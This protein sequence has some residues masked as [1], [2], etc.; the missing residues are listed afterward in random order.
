[1]IIAH[2][3]MF[4]ETPRR[5]PTFYECM[6]CN[7]FSFQIGIYASTPTKSTIYCKY[8]NKLRTYFE[9]TTN[10]FWNI[11]QIKDEPQ[12]AQGLSALC[13][14]NSSIA[15]WVRQSPKMNTRALSRSPAISTRLTTRPKVNNKTISHQNSGESPA[16]RDNESPLQRALQFG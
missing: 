5:Y 1:M 6:L 14:P 3:D 12:D 4:T 2:S 16:I 11:S 13:T 10:K 7:F 8:L 15:W 9:P